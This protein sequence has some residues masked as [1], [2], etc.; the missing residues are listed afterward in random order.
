MSEEVVINPETHD[1][2]INSENQDSLAQTEVVNSSEQTSTT[3]EETSSP[4]PSPPSSAGSGDEED[5]A[6][7]N[8]DKLHHSTN[9][10]RGEDEIRNDLEQL[11]LASNEAPEVTNIG[12]ELDS[13]HDSEYKPEDKVGLN[14]LFRCLVNY[15]LARR[16]SIIRLRK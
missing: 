8:E 9:H 13:D 2:M 11:H 16:V 3:P 5:A 4:S 10:S 15:I 7:P 14:V 12:L 1:E 6:K